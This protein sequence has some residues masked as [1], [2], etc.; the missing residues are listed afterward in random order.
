MD[1]IWKNI[2]RI[3]QGLWFTREKL[4]NKG[5]MKMY[6][7]DPRTILGAI[8][9]WTNEYYLKKQTSIEINS[10]TFDSTWKIM[11]EFNS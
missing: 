1:I 6:Q 4:P 10:S 9:N 11:P 8:K 7:K 5:S 3:K 2:S